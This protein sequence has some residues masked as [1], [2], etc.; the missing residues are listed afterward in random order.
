M[1]KAKDEEKGKEK[2]G[3]CSSFSI[4]GGE[5]NR[6]RILSITKD[7]RSFFRP[8]KATREGGGRALIGPRQCSEKKE[9]LV[10]TWAKNSSRFEQ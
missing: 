2:E 5:E 3:K 8:R 7:K 9:R 6:K 1:D 4:A 10:R